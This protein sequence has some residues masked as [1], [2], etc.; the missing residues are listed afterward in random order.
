MPTSGFVFKSQLGCL[1]PMLIIF[2]LFFGKL[3][4]SS[5]RLWLGIEGVL[6]LIFIINLNIM[7]RKIG[8]NFRSATQ[9]FAFEGQ[10][11]K[12]PEEVIDIQ[13]DVVEDKKELR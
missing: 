11:R 5:T 10:S 6:I 2:N 7:V 8:R 4:F 9:G 13:G 3:I 1:L 12:Q